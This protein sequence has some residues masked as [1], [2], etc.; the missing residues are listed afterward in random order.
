M[1]LFT[2]FN[3]ATS[4]AASAV[5]NLIETSN[6]P[7]M[8]NQLL[9]NDCFKAASTFFTSLC[10]ALVVW[11][12]VILLFKLVK[13]LARVVNTTI[14]A[15]LR[16]NVTALDILQAIMLYNLVVSMEAYSINQLVLLLL[17][18]SHLWSTITGRTIIG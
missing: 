15:V 2:A 8:Y 9:S 12:S 7:E 16:H 17:F 14:S 1:D 4:N 3:S 13:V 10:V 11:L 5:S 18:C 6:I